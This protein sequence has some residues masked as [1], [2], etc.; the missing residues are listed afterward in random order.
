MGMP[1]YSPIESH[2]MFKTFVR[3]LSTREKDAREL[4]AV[5]DKIKTSA[6]ESE[7][8]RAN[9]IAEVWAEARADA[10]KH[11]DKLRTETEIHEISDLQEL[12]VGY[13]IVDRE[14]DVFQRVSLKESGWR[15]MG[16]WR[17]YRL[18]EIQLPA[19]FLYGRG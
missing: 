6:S 1:E 17:P 10:E 14:G 18:E 9:L 13:V 2:L 4:A 3:L 8:E 11:L 5:W 16:K 12:K 15:M 19:V 7:I